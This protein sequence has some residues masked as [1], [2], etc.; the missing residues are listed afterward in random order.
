[1]LIFLNVITNITFWRYAVRH[2]RAGCL[3]VMWLVFVGCP[4]PLQTGTLPIQTGM[5]L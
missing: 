2:D 1:V 3:G 4:V 5:F